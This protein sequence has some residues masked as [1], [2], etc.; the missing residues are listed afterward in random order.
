MFIQDIL[1]MHTHVHVSKFD[2][3]EWD[4][5]NRLD[6]MCTFVIH[7]LIILINKRQ[8]QIKT[9]VFIYDQLKIKLL[10]CEF[11][12]CKKRKSKELT[13]Y[14]FLLNRLFM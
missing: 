11:H 12:S 9:V 7:L 10:Y 5:G 6:T 14:I 1:V 4:T 2:L 8:I 13:V 3:L